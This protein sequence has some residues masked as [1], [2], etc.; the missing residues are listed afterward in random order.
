MK[1]CGCRKLVYLV[2]YYKTQQNEKIKEEALLQAVMNTQVCPSYHRSV[3]VITGLSELSRVCPSY[4]GPVRVITGLS[5][6]SPVCQ[7]LSVDAIVQTYARL[8]F[9]IIQNIFRK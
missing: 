1:N 4:H 3:R 8:F 2:E 6:L 7:S 5:D 9:R